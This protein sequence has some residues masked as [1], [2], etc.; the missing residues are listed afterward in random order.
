LKIE[1][2]YVTVAGNSLDIWIDCIEVDFSGMTLADDD[3]YA[4]S[5]ADVSDWYLSGN[6]TDDSFSTDG[7]VLTWSLHDDGNSDYL[8]TDVPSCVYNYF[9]IRYKY[10][11]TDGGWITAYGKTEDWN[12]GDLV[13]WGSGAYLQD[14]ST[15]WITKRWKGTSDTIESIYFYASSLEKEFSIDYFRAGSDMGWQHD[16]STTTATRSNVGYMDI[17]SDGDILTAS[18]KAQTSPLTMAL[19]IDFDITTTEIDIETDYYQF[20]KMRYRITANN[21]TSGTPYVTLRIDGTAKSYTGELNDDGSWH[22]WRANIKAQ[23]GS[24][25]DTEFDIFGLAN[26]NNEYYSID[27]DYAKFYSIA[28]Y[29]YSASGVDVGDVL[30]CSSGVLNVVKTTTGSITIDYDPTLSVAVNTYNVWNITTSSSTL[31]KVNYK[32]NGVNEE[33]STITRGTY[34]N[35]PTLTD[36]WL[37]FYYSQTVSAIKFIE[38]NTAPS[39]I[40]SSAT[41]NDP[42]DDEEVTLS[43]VVTDAVAVYTVKFNAITYPAGFSDTDYSATEIQNNVWI[44]EFSTMT[45]GYYVFLITANDGANENSADEWSY[46]E[47]TVRDTS[48]TTLTLD[49]ALGLEWDDTYLNIWCEP[50]LACTLYIY[51]NGT[52]KAS[53]SVPAAGATVRY[54]LD[55]TEGLHDLDFMIS[56]GSTTLWR[57]DTYYTVTAKWSDIDVVDFIATGTVQSVLGYTWAR[58][59]N[60]STVYWQTEQEAGNVTSDINGAITITLTQASYAA[61]SYN[62]ELWTAATAERWVVPFTVIQLDFTSATFERL[63]PYEAM[64]LCTGE[65][66]TDQLYDI[67][68]SDGATSPSWLQVADNVEAP[69]VIS[70]DV[71]NSNQRSYKVVAVSRTTEGNYIESSAFTNS[72]TPGALPITEDR[73]GGGS[74]NLWVDPFAWV[75]L[76]GIIAVGAVAASTGRGGEIPNVR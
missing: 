74:Y 9:E 70:L 34:T 46:V 41:P 35:S 49:E 56:D 14:T 59:L 53:G 24:S 28:N 16:G 40:R 26:N 7:D 57:N 29:T 38:D 68:V 73:G 52:S 75:M 37:R 69:A 58:P 10:N 67:W 51:D 76:L 22:I 36:I 3:H 64:I 21:L 71:D 11:T 39:I 44:Y 15:D 43:A 27:I 33:H 6:E 12:G 55:N 13:S 17:S 50:S 32:V 30:Y 47:I 19:K 2:K 8:V 54:E 42:N 65:T 72:Y 25:S 5:F 23:G 4:E 66:Y 48:V 1:S 20:A 31:W 61:G 60:G 62:L 18:C 45:A 63:G